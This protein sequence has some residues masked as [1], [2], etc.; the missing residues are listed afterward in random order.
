[1][2][3]LKAL[4]ASSKIQGGVFTTGRFILGRAESCD[5]IIKQEGIS[6]V[7]AVIEILPNSAILYDMNST[8]GTY[9]NDEKI[10]SHEL[11]PGDI[12][13]LADVEFRFQHYMRTELASSI[14]DA[15]EPERGSASIVMRRELP[16]HAPIVSDLVPSIVHPLSSDPKAEFSEY[17]FE[18]K[19]DLYPI[20]KYQSIKHAVEVII[21]FKDQVLSI[22]YLPDGLST[23]Y[24]TGQGQ[25]NDE[26]ELPFLQKTEKYKFVEILKK[27]SIVHTIPGFGIFYLSSKRTDTGHQGASFELHDYDLVR[28]HKDDLQLFVRNVVAPP[29]VMSAPI[30]KKDPLFRNILLSC[31]ILMVAIISSIKQIPQEK[32]KNDSKSQVRL[33]MILDR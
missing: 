3:E 6:A 15:L 10:I 28:I 2:F 17:I 5:L 14:L 19:S 30:L 12:F 1:M 23:F 29:K 31:F 21:L 33:A 25:A 13:S 8:N 26:L 16:K 24:L 7:H 20:F 9:V 22:N 27:S 18:D 4:N 11:K 32:Q